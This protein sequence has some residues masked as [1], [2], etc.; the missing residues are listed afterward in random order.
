[1]MIRELK[2]REILGFLGLWRG[3][4]NRHCLSHPWKHQDLNVSNGPLKASKSSR[5]GLAE[6]V[7][8]GMKMLPFDVLQPRNTN[9]NC[10][11][12]AGSDCTVMSGDTACAVMPAGQ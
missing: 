10:N 11:G 3:T 8:L 6:Q 4:W 12:A 9:K 2:Y 1:M 5:F 7:L